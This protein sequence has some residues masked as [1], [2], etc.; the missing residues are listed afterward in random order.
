MSHSSSGNR[1]NVKYVKVT[2]DGC[3]AEC[4]SSSNFKFP[5]YVFL[6]ETHTSDVM[7]AERGGVVR[8]R[9]CVKMQF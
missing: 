1:K 9:E 8:E 7:K 2:E 5:S 6:T 3:G 4:K